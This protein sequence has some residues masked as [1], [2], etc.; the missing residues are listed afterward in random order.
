MSA[1]LLERSS[2]KT[3]G[4]LIEIKH[5]FE[6]CWS[7]IKPYLPE[8]IDKDRDVISWRMLRKYTVAQFRVARREFD[9]AREIFSDLE[10]STGFSKFEA[11]NQEFLKMI[12]IKVTGKSNR[13]GPMI[14]GLR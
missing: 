7:E 12:D 5:G 10:E 11:D 1:E 8:H 2:E 4:D 6:E 9:E 3:K 13:G 14:N